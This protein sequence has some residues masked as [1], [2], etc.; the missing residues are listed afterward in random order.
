[1]LRARLSSP[2]GRRRR[3]CNSG[4][5]ARTRRDVKSKWTFASAEPLNKRCRSRA[6]GHSHSRVSTRRSPI[7]PISAVTPPRTWSS[8]SSKRGTAREWSSRRRDCP[9]RF[10]ISWRRAPRSRSR[11]LRRRWRVRALLVRLQ[12]RAREWAEVHTDAL[13]AGPLTAPHVHVK[14]RK[15]VQVMFQWKKSPQGLV[16]AGWLAALAVTAHARPL[17]GEARESMSFLSWVVLGLL[18][19]FIGSM[20]S[21]RR[22]EGVLLDILLGIAGAFAGGWI[23]RIFG[24]P[25]VTGLNVY[26]IIVAVIGA[27]ILLSIYHLS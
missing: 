20:L 10:A 14:Q 8:N 16:V 24:A 22:G 21:N 23:F 1:M 19:G 18:A 11:N 25:G 12:R 27:V 13:T 9:G 5:A 7:Q 15:V 26:S 4:R 17:T 2:G 6:P 3:R